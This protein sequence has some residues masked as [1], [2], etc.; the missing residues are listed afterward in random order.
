VLQSSSLQDEAVV[1]LMPG[2]VLL[3]SKGAQGLPGYGRSELAFL[4]L[5]LLPDNTLSVNIIHSQTLAVPLF[6]FCVSSSYGVARAIGHGMT[7]RG[8]TIYAF[9]ISEDSHMGYSVSHIMLPRINLV[10]A[11]VFDGFRGRL[12]NTG[13]ESLASMVEILDYV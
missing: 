4:H 3:V 1:P 8:M 5:H 7:T 9:S 12:C 13:H 6:N 10:D 2:M 11:T